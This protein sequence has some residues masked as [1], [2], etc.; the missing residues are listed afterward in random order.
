[1]KGTPS[2]HIASKTDVTEQENNI[3]RRCFTGWGSEGVKK[4]DMT[5]QN[6]CE[7]S[8][9]PL[10]PSHE[11]TVGVVCWGGNISEHEKGRLDKSGLEM[12][13][14]LLVLVVGALKRFILGGSDV[15]LQLS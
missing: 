2:K 1:M 15:N 11:T 13:P 7:F 3:Q 9:R 8:G 12:G 6:M 14:K 10:F 5:I 4:N